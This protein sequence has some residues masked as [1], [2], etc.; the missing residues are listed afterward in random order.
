[1]AN[2]QQ[3]LRHNIWKTKI[4]K[5]KLNTKKAKTNNKILIEV[6]AQHPLINGKKPNKEF[7]ERLLLGIKLYKE[8]K[9]KGKEVYIYVPGSLHT[10]RGKTDK[11][12]LSE[13]GTNYLISKRIPKK[14]MFGD[15]TN[16]KYTNGK[17]VYH[18]EGECIVAVKL[19]NDLKA[20]ELHCVC[21]PAQ[22]MRK[23]LKYIDLGYIPYVHTVSCD[24]MF[25]DYVDELF[26]AI[27][28]LLKSIK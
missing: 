18:S 8:Y 13:A 28:T 22:M 2:R 27:P 21:S 3:S 20:S 10:Y 19:F 9:K 5:A 26:V 24:E 17:G 7:E 16:I 1:M 14:Y 23:V 12:T 6:A 4:K 15:E 11:I 25:H